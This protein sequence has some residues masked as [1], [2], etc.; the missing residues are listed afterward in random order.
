MVFLDVA[1]EAPSYKDRS[2]GGKG[3]NNPTQ[4]SEEGVWVL[5][6]VKSGNVSVLQICFTLENPAH[7][8][9]M[10]NYP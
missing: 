1:V 9:E 10:E 8:P 7:S 5:L 2:Q 4:P 3:I 6:K